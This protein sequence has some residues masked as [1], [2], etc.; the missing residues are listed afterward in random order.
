MSEVIIYS[1]ISAALR[2]VDGQLQSIDVNLVDPTDDI[3][4]MEV[5]G[6][7]V[8]D[9]VTQYQQDMIDRTDSKQVPEHVYLSVS[10][11]GSVQ[12]QSV[13]A[14]SEQPE[15]DPYR[16]LRTGQH[17]NSRVFWYD[18]ERDV[19]ESVAL[20]FINALAADYALVGWRG[21]HMLTAVRVSDRDDG[22]GFRAELL[23]DEDYH[24]ENFPN[25]RR[26]FDDAVARGMKADD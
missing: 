9:W 25:F 23:D 8:E 24:L 19:P 4:R 11:D 10:Q 16:G 13:A 14:V 3:L 2:F 18:D 1:S 26:W 7:V 22:L 12:V 6:Q 5:D 21:K 20:E 17:F 15:R